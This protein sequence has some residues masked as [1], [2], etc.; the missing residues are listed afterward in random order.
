M[1]IVDAY[2]LTQT[3]NAPTTE[4][5]FARLK[6]QFTANSYIE[7][8]YSAPQGRAA[9]GLVKAAISMLDGPLCAGDSCFFSDSGKIFGGTLQK[10][11][12]CAYTVANGA[13][14]PAWKGGETIGIGVHSENL[15][16]TRYECEKL[17]PF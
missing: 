10:D 14:G 9:I 17:S 7:F 5:Y 11:S 3:A 12:S 6:K 13:F 2:T 15:I 4:L 16:F 1:K 8:R